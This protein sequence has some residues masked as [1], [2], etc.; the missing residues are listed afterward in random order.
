MNGLFRA[1]ALLLFVWYSP[2]GIFRLEFAGRVADLRVDVGSIGAHFES[3]TDPRHERN[4]KHLLVDIVAISIG[5]ILCGASDPTA[6][7]RLGQVEARVVG[8]VFRAT[9]RHS[10]ARLSASLADDPQPEAF[11]KCFEEWIA[12][13]VEA[14]INP[15]AL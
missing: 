8:Q 11:Q 1:L 7:H 15:V 2:P 5:G 14:D 9:A 13:G 10:V 6:I 3:L 4:R 12:N